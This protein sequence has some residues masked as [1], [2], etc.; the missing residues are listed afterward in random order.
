VTKTLIHIENSNHVLPSFW[1]VEDAQPRDI[2]SRARKVVVNRPQ[3][4]SGNVLKVSK[5]PS[6]YVRGGRNVDSFSLFQ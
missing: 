1:R 2:G 3:V 4:I 5:G 6:L